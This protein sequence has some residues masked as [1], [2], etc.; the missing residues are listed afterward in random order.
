[1][2]PR[3]L[4]TLS[5]ASRSTRAFAMRR[6][7]QGMVLIVVLIMLTVMTILGI[8]TMGNTSMEERM[9]ANVQEYNRAFQVAESGIAAHFKEGDAL[10]STATPPGT[11][12]GPVIH[13]YDF[14]GGEESVTTR[15][16]Y[17]AK[18]REAPPGYSMGGPFRAHYFTMDSAG[19]TNGG[20]TSR[21]RQG[22]YVIGPG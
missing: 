10:L 4:T 13:N 15:S 3:T 18:G 5:D 1:M 19:T 21:H 6:G 12:P 20:A 17:E 9:A 7:E 16:W 8:T 11:A 22:Y 14:R 2:K